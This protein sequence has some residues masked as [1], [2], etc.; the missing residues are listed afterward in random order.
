MA[1]DL[2]IVRGCLMGRM[3]SLPAFTALTIGPH[4]AA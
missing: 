2:A 4:P 1:S 3:C